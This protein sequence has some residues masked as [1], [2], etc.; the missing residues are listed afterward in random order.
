MS[1]E[2]RVKFLVNA[3]YYGV[4][5]VLAL[6]LLKFGWDYLSPFVTGFIVAY[7]LKPVINKINVYLKI[8]RSIAAVLC[9]LL[10]YGVTVWL[11]VLVGVQLALLI[12]NRFYL[13][14]DFY[15]AEIVP[16]VTRLLDWVQSF[17]VSIDPGVQ[18]AVEEAINNIMANMGTYI[19]DISMGVLGYISTAATKVPAFLIRTL[20]T[21]IASFFISLDYY[22]LTYFIARQLN[23]KQI[24]MLYEVETYTKSALLKYIKSY[25]LIMFITFCE[26]GTGLFLLGVE[27]P[28]LIAILIAAFDILPVLGSGGILVPWAVISLVT[29]D[30]FLGVGIA[31]LYVT[32]TVIRNIIEPKIVGRQVGLHPVVT[33]ACMYV[34]TM[35]MGIL[36]L[37]LFPV[38]MS[39]LIQLND[40]GKIKI[41]K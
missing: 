20:I 26:I 30:I 23:T 39:I 33:L 36:G 16:V 21:V 2:K 6:L 4:I 29:G 41:F 1:Y 40:S 24:T 5:A 37:F 32:I 10:F 25:A 12:R 11:L 13:L 7:F 34:G 8:K 17:L 14:P 22:K 38:S 28:F 18:S 3:L 9:V 31:I 27:K 19:S 35:V 15:S